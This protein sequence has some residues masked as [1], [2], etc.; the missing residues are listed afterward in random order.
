[1]FLSLL[2]SLTL[3]HVYCWEWTLSSTVFTLYIVTVQLSKACLSMSISSSVIQAAQQPVDCSQHHESDIPQSTGWLQSKRN[4]NML[5][6]F[7]SDKSI[8]IKLLQITKITEVYVLSSQCFTDSVS[9]NCFATFTQ[10]HLF[11]FLWSLLVCMAFFFFFFKRVC[12][13]MLV[14]CKSLLSSYSSAH[15]LVLWF[16]ITSPSLDGYYS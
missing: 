9:L 8:S 14:W 16:Y 15:T 10:K 6:V 2:L 11:P 3:R 12:S 7:G 5:S 4:H 1:M 13:T